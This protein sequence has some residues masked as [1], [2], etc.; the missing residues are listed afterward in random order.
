LVAPPVQ[1]PNTSPSLS[2]YPA[3]HHAHSTSVR[4]LVHCASPYTS[5]SAPAHGALP[6]A[7]LSGASAAAAASATIRLARASSM[8]S[9]SSTAVPV[10]STTSNAT[11]P[12]AA[13]GA[14]E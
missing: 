12:S 7:T 6:L 11:R 4:S 3:R 9:G 10:S 13:T 1:S 2:T 14:S 8:L 5:S